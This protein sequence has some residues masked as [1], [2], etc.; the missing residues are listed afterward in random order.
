[1][2]GWMCCDG[3]GGA[4][5]SRSGTEMMGAASFCARIEGMRKERWR[6]GDLERISSKSSHVSVVGEEGR[7]RACRCQGMEAHASGSF[8]G[9]KRNRM[10]L[11]VPVGSMH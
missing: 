9:G 6:R 7:G 1:M 8:G 10:Y 4:V 11:K 5:T 2:A 3:K